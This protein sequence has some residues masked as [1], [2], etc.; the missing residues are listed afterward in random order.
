M[1]WYLQLLG[2]VLGFQLFNP[3][4]QGLH[5]NLDCTGQGMSCWSIGGSLFQLQQAVVVALLGVLKRL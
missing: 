2:P 4:K 5:P 1:A 3:S